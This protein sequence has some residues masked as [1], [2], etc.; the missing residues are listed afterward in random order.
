MHGGEKSD[1]VIVA[2]KPTNKVWRTTRRSW[3]S[4]GPHPRGN[5]RSLHVP[6]TG[7]GIVCHRGMDRLRLGAVCLFPNVMRASATLRE[8]PC[9]LAG[10]HGSVR[11]PSGGPWGYRDLMELYAERTQTASGVVCRARH[12]ACAG[13]GSVSRRDACAVHYA[14]LCVVFGKAG[15]VMIGLGASRRYFFCRKPADMRKSFDGRKP[16]E[17]AAG[18]SNP[19]SLVCCAARQ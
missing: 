2:V 3:W 13:R 19:L 11:G 1:A 15:A 5:R 4:E 12:L 10:T 14:G 16:P 8:G 18:I 9:A 17:L 7:P 6:G